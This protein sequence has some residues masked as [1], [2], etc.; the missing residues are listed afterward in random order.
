M[1]RD[2]EAGRQPGQFPTPPTELAVSTTAPTGAPLQPP[3][4]RLEVELPFEST[5]SIT[6]RKL[7]QFTITETQITSERAQQ[8]GIPQTTQVVEMKQELQARIQGTVGR[9]TTVNV[10][11]DDTKQNTQDF[12]VVYKGDPDELVQEAAFGDITLS[13]PNTE[14]VNYNKQLFGVRAHLKY[15]KAEVYAIGSRT[16]GTTETKRFTGATTQTQ[17]NINDISY[18][19]RSFYDLTYGGGSFTSGNTV[20]PITQ[21][22][23]QVF[24]D[25]QNPFNNTINTQHFNVETSTGGTLSG[26]FDQLFPGRDYIVDYS[27]GVINFLRPLASNALVAVDYTFKD[28]TRLSNKGTHPSLR[29]VLKDVF[30][31]P[32]V[33]QELKTYYSIGQPRITRDNGRGNF[34]LKVL[35]LN[36]NDV[37]SSVGVAYPN[38][39]TVNFEQ[40]IFFL[41]APIQNHPEIYTP[42][43]THDFTFFLQYQFQVKTYS[44]RPNLVI[45]SEHLTMNGKPLT[46]DSDYIIDYDLGQVTFLHPE[47]I[48]DSTQVEVTYEFAPFGSQLGDTLVGTRGVLSPLP[49]WKIGSSVLYDFA[50]KPL[51][52]PDVREMPQSSLVVGADTQ[53]EKVKI[54]LLPIVSTF[55]GEVAQSRLNPDL[56]DKALVESFEGL[57]QEDLASPLV[58]NWQISSNPPGGTPIPHLPDTT[59]SNETGKV[60]DRNPGVTGTNNSTEQVLRMDYSL[61]GGPVEQVSYAQVYSPIGRDFSRKQTLEVWVNGAGAGGAGVD[62]IVDLGLPKEDVENTGIIETEDVNHT[63]FLQA[64]E[65]VGWTYH[66]P[67]PDLTSGWSCS[68][69]G[70]CS[71]TDPDDQTFQIGTNNG[72]LDSED[73]NNN[74]R[75][76]PEQMVRPG[77]PIFQLSSG[78]VAT[79][80][81]THQQQTLK[82]LN[83]TGWKVFSIP[84]NIQPSEVTAWQAVVAVRV[85]LRNATQQLQGSAADRAGTIRLGPLDVVGNS[86]TPAVTSVATSS[87]S[88][89]AVNNVDNP[90]YQPLFNSPQYTDLYPNQTTNGQQIRE[91][92]LQLSFLLDP[93][94]TATTQEVFSTPR[95]LSRFKQFRFFAQLPSGSASPFTLFLQIGSNTQFLEY[96]VTVSA[97]DPNWKNGWRLLTANLVDTSGGQTPNTWQTSDPGATTSVGPGG[98]PPLTQISQI[99]IGVKNPGSSQIQSRIWVD[100]IYESQAQVRV[101]LAQKYSLDNTIPGWGGFGGNLRDV[102]RNFQTPSTTI[103]NQDNTDE[104]GYINFTR[105][106]FL[107]L[108][109]TTGLT[110]TVTPNATQTGSSQLVSILANGRTQTLTQNLRAQLLLPKMPVIGFTYDRAKTDTDLLVRTDDRQMMTGTLDYAL[111][112]KPNLM[113]G[114]GLTFRPLPTDLSLTGSRQLYFLKFGSKDALAAQGL[115]TRPFDNTSSVEITDNY[116][117]R[118][119]LLP[120]DGLKL[121]PSYNLKL[122]RQ[123]DRFRDDEY[124]AANASGVDLGPAQNFP[125]GRAFNASLAGSLRVLRWFEPQFSYN[126]NTTETNLLPSFSSSTITPGQGTSTS[127]IT[128]ITAFDFKNIDR[129]GTANFSWAFLARQA[130]PNSK[131]F[132]SFSGSSSYLLENGD[133]YQNVDKNFNTLNQLW[134]GSP[135]AVNN[136]EAQRTQFTRRGTVRLLTNWS[137]LEAYPMPFRLDPLRT[138]N[139][140]N[141]YTDTRQ[142]QETTGTA[143]DSKTTI[144]PDMILTIRDTEKFYGME[145]ALTNSRL[146]LRGTLRDTDTFGIDDAKSTTLG[147]EYLF[148]VLRK[149]DLA[150]NYNVTTT[151]DFNEVTGNNNSTGKTTSFSTQLGWTLGIWRYTPRFEMNVNQT[152]NASDVLTADITERIYSLQMYGDIARPLSLKLPFLRNPLGLANRLLLTINLKLDQRRTSLDVADDYT[153]TYTGTISGDYS[154]SQNFKLTLGGGYSKIIHQAAFQLLNVS[155]YN[156]TTALTIQF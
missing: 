124:T 121:N 75:L 68:S 93:G 125:K 118:M 112:W 52:P 149:V 115:F 147:F 54:P 5:L 106:P 35:D 109:Y 100:D 99:M 51:E 62:F 37:G 11:Y 82:D 97:A 56:F 19:R 32:G 14:F 64:N 122:I 152:K 151:S 16:K 87:A 13:L 31:T 141:T 74:G 78:I 9:K 69:L 65:D 77:S 45:Q 137:P 154:I 46:R 101:G 33:T 114:T 104:S 27:R 57:K 53:L 71:T 42:S 103:T 155:S 135:L 20:L 89:Q 131:L 41:N 7:I 73:L 21:G 26:D 129:T 132:R 153:D 133:S 1:R 139:I 39:I 43:P 105:L 138:M 146:T 55:K 66:D 72:K 67:G 10:N 142:H 96:D 38:Q 145:R 143:T 58:I 15:K 2:L 30:E 98:A 22:S 136:P 34:I 17:Q 84:L 6:G 47:D 156:L 127:T 28:G 134:V 90:D 61:K 76:D 111:P 49:N 113:A 110:T 70:N 120:W 117:T 24:V 81:I 102:N 148:T 29:K 44:L 3:P 130:F 18:I 128:G 25:D 88:V 85:T 123:E 144:L 63:G 80:P 107:P 36:Q 94:Q 91:Q 12:S 8:L 86:F 108:S 116:S 95:D 79:D 126:V 48:T 119:A 59:L 60:S 23:E 150:T 92:A 4:G 140:T 83:F 40:G 50:P